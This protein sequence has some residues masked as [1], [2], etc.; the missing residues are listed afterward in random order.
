[1]RLNRYLPLVALAALITV[2]A[3]FKPSDDG[4]LTA[5]EQ[6]GREIYLRGTSPSGKITSAVMGNGGAEIP[7]SSLACANCHGREG[8]GKNE[9]GV[10]PSNLTW[11]SLT[12]PYPVTAPSGRTHSAY[13]ESLFKR[14]ITMGFD[15]GGNQL[16]VAMPRY[17]MSLDDVA[18][19]IAYIKKL[20]K[21]TDP[22][23]TETTIQVGT[24]VP[25][26]GPLS[27]MGKALSSVL[28]AYFEELNAQGGIFGRKVELQVL[29]GD[30]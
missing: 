23:L 15:P 14:A 25:A 7:A 9:G 24:V 6:R 11:D 17:R 8:L 22:G 27:E 5:Q 28:K 2:S 18:D 21:S 26:Q 16:Q 29:S 30:S 10:S 1:M 4:G 12:R 13:D 19:L 3:A 20:G